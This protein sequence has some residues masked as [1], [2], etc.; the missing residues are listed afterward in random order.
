MEKKPNICISRDVLLSV[1]CW[2]MVTLPVGQEMMMEIMDKY[3]QAGEALAEKENDV[4]QLAKQVSSSSELSCY[5]TVLSLHFLAQS[6]GTAWS[7]SRVRDG[8]FGLYRR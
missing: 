1:C 6:H 2:R 3:V 5:Y 8:C 4:R 7:F